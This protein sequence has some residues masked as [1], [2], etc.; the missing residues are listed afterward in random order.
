MSDPAADPDWYLDNVVL[1]AGAVPRR[2]GP[3]EEWRRSWERTCVR[4]RDAH[5]DAAERRVLAAALGQGFVVARAEVRELGVPDAR[6]R[7]LVRRGV[8]S[9]A[10]FGVVAVL[11]PVGEDVER[12]RRVHALRS[13]A[14][15]L[16]RPEHA[17]SA[18]SAAIVHGL[19]VIAVPP[20][21][22]LTRRRPAPDGR[23]GGSLVRS[24]RLDDVDL[25][26]WFG[27]PVTTVARTLGDLARTDPA[28][29]LMA[30]DAARREGLVTT[31]DIDG[32]L[33]RMTGWPGVRHARAALALASPLAESPLESLTRWVVHLA[34]LPQPELQVEI[35]DPVSGRTYRVDL[36]WRA[37]RLVL[38]ADGRGKY[39]GDALWRE[40][41]RE[42]ALTRAGY[43]VERVTWDDLMR[44]RA[45]T[46]E[47]WRRVYFAASRPS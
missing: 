7:S 22:V 20:A 26:E 37:R 17:V 16:T 47:R 38:E 21:P 13:A 43:R 28:G 46:I 11:A 45:A 12:R 9:A 27:V 2:L 5:V 36:L 8:W 3:V 29:A 4:A 18:A 25:T 1:P 39:S 6:V 34:G 32:V 35:T 33:G 10:G 42:L 24:A 15:A 44:Y 23:R 41:Q 31:A 30:A 40:K 14:A 19:P